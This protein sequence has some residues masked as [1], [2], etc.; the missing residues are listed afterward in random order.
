MRDP[1]RHYYAHKAV[2]DFIILT[3][4][5]YFKEED[6]RHLFESNSLLNYLNDMIVNLLDS[7]CQ[8]YFDYEMEHDPMLL[9]HSNSS[10]HQSRFTIPEIEKKLVHTEYNLTHA[11]NL[12]SLCTD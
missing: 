6:I 11:H 3:K 1:Q 5:S 7:F 9:I 10:E 8:M 2:K 4:K 12:V